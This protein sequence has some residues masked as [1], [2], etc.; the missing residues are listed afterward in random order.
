MLP[1]PQAITEQR[2]SLDRI[3]RF[4]RSMPALD[5]GARSGARSRRS[6]RRSIPALDPGARSRRSIP[7]L[8]PGARSRRSIPALDP[9]LFAR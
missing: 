3:A 4:R 8:D 7:P 9:A 5:P 6:I 2:A 1:P